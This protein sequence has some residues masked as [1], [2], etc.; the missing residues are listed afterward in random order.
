MKNILVIG[1]GRSATALI[2]YVLKNAAEKGWFVTVADADPDL[3]AKKVNNHPN[4]R[5]TWLDVMKPNDRREVIERND[6]IVSLLPAHLHFRIAKDCIKYKKHL[7]TASYVSQE[8]YRLGEEA[9]KADLIFMGEMGLDPGIDHMSAMKTIDELRNKGAEI[10]DFRSYAG[11]LIAPESDDNPWHYKFTWNPR[12]VVR[13]GQGTAQYLEEGKYKYIPYSRLFKQYKVI[14]VPGMGEFEAYANRDSLLYRER[15]GLGDIPNILR[16]TL[17]KRGFC[18][19]WSALVKI[20]LTDDSYP[21][22]CTDGLTY[23]DFVEAYLPKGKRNE[24]MRERLSQLLKI[25]IDSDVM[26]KLEW[27][28]LFSREKIGLRKASP[29]RILQQL[30]EKKWT[31]KEEDLDMI[32]MQHE[33]IYN[34]DGKKQKLT[35]SMVLKGEDSI[36]TAMAKLV[37]LPL[38]I[39]VKLIIDGKIKSTGV[40]IPVMEEVY[41]PVLEELEDYGVVFKEQLEELS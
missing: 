29:A 32:V 18:E 17:R 26:S 6:V 13:A 36:N 39:F 40:N 23:F 27:L 37:G 25:D 3:A 20:G 14:E 28:D 9:R 8:M 41:T 15:Y 33:F 22:V 10:I 31:L 19:A 12:N 30:L 1:A 5:A 24:S 34:L 4:G 11:G 7:V 2:N 16:A 21:I 38:G 35:S